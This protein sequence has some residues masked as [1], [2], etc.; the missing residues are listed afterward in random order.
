MALIRGWAAYLHIR[1]AGCRSPHL[2]NPRGVLRTVLAGGGD[3]VGRCRTVDDS[4]WGGDCSGYVGG[5]DH[6]RCN[7]YGS[8]GYCYHI[9]CYEYDRCDCDAGGNVWERC[10]GGGFRDGV[11]CSGGAGQSTY[12]DATENRWYAARFAAQVYR[13]GVCRKTH[14]DGTEDPL[15]AAR[16]VVLASGWQK[17]QQRVLECPSAWKRRRRHVVGRSRRTDWSEN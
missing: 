10:G 11:Y 12:L 16:S 6:G 8:S 7:Y 13:D 17:V 1:L 3:P 2:L 4:L 5:V 9:G 14:L 15:D